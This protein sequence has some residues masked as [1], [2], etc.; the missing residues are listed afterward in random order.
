MVS[1]TEGGKGT[2]LQFASDERWALL[3][4]HFEV[5]KCLLELTVIKPFSVVTV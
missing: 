4:N 3:F 2:E 5:S 1:Q